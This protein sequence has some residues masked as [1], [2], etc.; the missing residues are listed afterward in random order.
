MKGW[1]TMFN[2]IGVAIILLMLQCI[3]V[4]WDAW[5][6]DFDTARL[7][8][9]SDYATEAGFIKSMSSGNLGISYDDLT[10]AELSPEKTLY[11]FE[12][13]MCIGYDKVPNEENIDKVN[14]LIETSVLACSD[15]Y[16]ITPINKN[17]FERKE[18][19]YEWTN[20]IPYVIKKNDMSTS[21]I[22]SITSKSVM[23]TNELDSALFTMQGS[24][25]RII[26]NSKS[27]VSFES[28]GSVGISKSDRNLILSIINRQLNGAIIDNI[29]N[30]Q[31]ENGEINHKFYLPSEQ[32]SSG[33]NEVNSPSLLVILN[34]KGFETNGYINKTVMSGYKLIRK[35]YVIGYSYQD[36]NEDGSLKPGIKYNYCYETQLPEGY[37]TGTDT[38]GPINVL[39]FF[40][41]VDKAAMEGYLPDLAYLQ[42]R[43]R[44][45]KK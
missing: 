19:A 22:N 23:K 25:V 4:Q 36:K 35:M 13:V 24:D 30:L 11:G 18:L 29:V 38:R 32:T 14:S 1:S 27:D 6:K 8:Y 3:Y 43:I 2:L 17:N 10:G 9:Q 15:G 16:Y 33:I 20:K 41:S 26:D 21:L 5:D 42:H 40:T 44:Y 37:E 34:G 45:D 7:S 12:I 31:N 28:V 39:K